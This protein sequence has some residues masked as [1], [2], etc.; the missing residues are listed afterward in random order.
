MVGPAVISCDNCGVPTAC[1]Y[2]FI[3][4]YF[5]PGK[6]SRII[7]FSFP[8]IDLPKEVL[9]NSVLKKSE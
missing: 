5:F 2:L 1:L 6:V 7:C 8:L 9:K 3:S 4:F